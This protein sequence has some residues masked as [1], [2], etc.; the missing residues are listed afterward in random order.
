M[1]FADGFWLNQRGYEVNYMVQAYDVVEVENGFMVVATPFSGRER[2]KLLGSANLEITYTS[3]FE[4]VIRVNMTHHKGY[5]D[6][7]PHFV[8]N[9]GSYKPAVTITEHEAVL[10]SGDTRVV[11][12]RDNWEVSY[13][14]KDKKLTS[15]GWRSTGVIKESAFKQQARMAVQ[16]D[17]TFWSYPADP[18]KTYIREQLDTSV[19]EY[20]YGFGEKFTTFTKNGQNVEI[21]NADGGT[22][23]DQS[24]KSVPFYVSSRGYG[25]FVNSTDK[26]SFEVCSDTVS[27]VSFTLPGENMEYFVFGGENLTEVMKGYTDL[28]G[29]PSLPPAFS[30]G[31]WLT[32][33]FTTS[34]DEA[35]IT[36]FIDGMAERDIPLQVFH[37]DCFWM[38]GLEWCNFEWDTEQFPDPEGLLKR[39]HETKGL[40]TCVWINP[41]VGQ[42]SRLFDEGMEHGYF[43]KNTDGSV[44]Q[45][46][47]WQPG[48]AIVDF[49]NPDA[50]KWYAGY[51][52][53][54]CEMGVDT[55]KTDF[56]ERIPTRDVVYHNGADPIK[57][58]NF[59]TYLY[60]ECVFGV[61]KEYYGENKACL[62]AR[63]ATAGGQKFP[64][65]WGG[66]CSG[67][68][69]SMAEVVR[70]CLSL[71]ISG[72]GYTSHD[73]AGFEATATPDIYKRWAAFGLFSTHSRLHGNQS[74][75]VPWLFDDESCDVLRFFTK[76]KGE[77]MP[78]IWSQA[79]NTH[80]VGV[81]M[82]RAMVIDFADDPACLTLDRQYMLGDNILVA[83]IL[84]EDGIAQYYVPEGRWTDI[85]T[86]KVFEGGR[87]YTHK[88]SYFEIPALARPNSIIA[89]G[90]FK[91]DIEYDYLDGTNFTIYEPEDGKTIVCPIYDTEANKVFELKATRNGN[92]IE[93]EYTDTKA[94]FKISVAG[95]D[96]CVEIT[97]D[98]ENGKVIIEL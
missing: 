89:Y 27:K 19:G 67:N 96:K 52:R 59:Y 84:N 24:Y 33:S 44:F 15:G 58:H 42:R 45:C 69:N 57:M 56:G 29:K 16:A 41:Y 23:S 93:C 49:T 88:C 11:V 1:K 51:L 31:L 17:D 39:L 46:D 95:T 98:A 74:Y 62:F 97:P 53:K 50:C 70:G 36:G 6:N 43:I 5:K 26:V 18:H 76:K 54:L 14:Y 34:Y 4:N 3:E 94:G 37:F 75:R 20:F 80:E 21:W 30:F 61:L 65:H 10:V 40:K 38:K 47:E 72:F 12:S 77:L 48:M 64:V 9:K 90:N 7:G 32:S 28:T 63:S 87:W 22:C 25:I 82:M 35:T 2:Y 81:T 8:L 79:I 91:R 60:N 55:F 68:Y 78:Y 66:D 85:I 13:Y 73:M 92:K 86:G 83:P 71:C